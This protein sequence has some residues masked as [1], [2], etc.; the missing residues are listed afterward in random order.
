MGFHCRCTAAS[1]YTVSLKGLSAPEVLLEFK[2]KDMA[3]SYGVVLS[4]FTFLWLSLPFRN[5][6][7]KRVENGKRSVFFISLYQCFHSRLEKVTH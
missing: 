6:D 3:S 5:Q 1:R 7:F 4:G 2:F